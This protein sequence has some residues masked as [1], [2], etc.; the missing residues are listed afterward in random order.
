MKTNPLSIKNI[1]KIATN[2]RNQFNISEDDAFPI[3][4]VLDQLFVDGSLSIQYLDDDNQMFELDT[5]AKYNA[6]ENFII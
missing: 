3:L 5:P 2:I 4:E 6:N 1:E